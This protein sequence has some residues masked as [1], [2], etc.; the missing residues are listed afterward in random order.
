MAL[1]ASV[2]WNLP[3]LASSIG[4][5]FQ[6]RS[7]SSR[8]AAKRRSCSSSDTENHSLNRWMPLFTSERSNDGACRMNSM[9]SA[10]CRSP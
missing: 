4:D 6:R 5:S 7:G 8:R 2:S 1:R 10:A 3:R 9:Y